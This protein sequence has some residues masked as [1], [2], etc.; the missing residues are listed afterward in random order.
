VTRDGYYVMSAFCVA[1]GAALLV[2]YILPT[3]KRLQGV[4][5]WVVDDEADR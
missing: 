3:V 2:W 5:G 4:L 1:S